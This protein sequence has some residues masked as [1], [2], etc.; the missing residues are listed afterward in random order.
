MNGAQPHP[1]KPPGFVRAAAA[2]VLLASSAVAADPAP[3]PY[4]LGASDWFWA[5]AAL[6]LGLSGQIRYWGMDPVDTASLD[7]NRDLWP[8]DRWAAGLRSPAA[9]LASDLMIY[10]MVAAPMGLALVNARGSGGWDGSN[11]WN[12]FIAEAVI[13]SEAMALSSGLDFWVRSLRIHAR[14]LVYDKSAPASERLSGEASGSFYSGHANAAFL[15]ATYFAYTWTLRHPGHE[16]NG[17]VWTGAL[18]AA[19]GVAGLRIAAG[20][21]YLSDVLAGA[22][23]GAGFGWLFPWMHRRSAEAGGKGLGLGLGPGGDPVVTWR[24]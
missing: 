13:Y 20:K 9:G 10:S 1:K 22:A 21:H 6:G 16:S 11:G 14:P 3:G 17:W 8:M 23:A 24:F 2:A 5:P 4:A 12:G 15:S 18:S 19:A 7:R